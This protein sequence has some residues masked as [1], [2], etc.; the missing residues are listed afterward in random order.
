MQK[1]AHRKQILSEIR[2][3]LPLGNWGYLSQGKFLTLSKICWMKS[4]ESHV[5][6]DYNFFFIFA[7]TKTFESPL[8]CKEVKP[9]SVLKEINPACFFGSADA[10]S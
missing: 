9:Q 8:F 3:I 1:Q 7:I 2:W 6:G 4:K 10:E 5:T